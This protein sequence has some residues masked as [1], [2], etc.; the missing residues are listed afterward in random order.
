[1][2][3]YLKHMRFSLEHDSENTALGYSNISGPIFICFSVALYVRSREFLWQEGHTAF[4][5]K[6]EADEEVFVRVKSCLLICRF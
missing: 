3:A 5:T 4:A 1:M 2:V 6:P